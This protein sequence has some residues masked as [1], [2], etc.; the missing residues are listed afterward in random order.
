MED[1]QF[2]HKE[3][4]ALW[5][6]HKDVLAKTSQSY[7]DHILGDLNK[8]IDQFIE[9]K[10]TV[11]DFSSKSEEE[12]LP[13]RNCRKTV[14]EILKQQKNKLS[15]DY[16]TQKSLDPAIKLIK[17]LALKEKYSIV[18]K[19][20]FQGY[21]LKSNGRILL[22]L[23]KLW[24][25]LKLGFNTQLKVFYNLSRKLFRRELLDVQS[26]RKRR[27]LYRNMMIHYLGLE[28]QNKLIP[29]LKELMVFKSEILSKAWDLDDISVDDLEL[30]E[31]LNKEKDILN[32]SEFDEKLLEL[33]NLVSSRNKDFQ[34]KTD[35]A[36]LEA[37]QQFDLDFA[38]ADTPDLSNKKFTKNNLKQ[39]EENLFNNCESFLQKWELTHLALIDDW[40]LDVEIM[41]LYFNVLN[42][43]AQLNHQIS[44]YVNQNLSLNLEKLK[45]YLNESYQRI[46]NTKTTKELRSLL[47]LERKKNSSEFVD[48]ML[49]GTINKI[50]D[51]INQYLNSFNEKTLIFVDQVS[52]KRAF[53]QGK[54]YSKA[55]KTSDVSWLSPQDLLRFEAL[56]GLAN[57]IKD[58]ETFVSSHLEKAR[59]KLIALGTVSDF[60]LESAQ[61]MINE[62]KASYKEA[63][64][65]VFDGYER[66]LKHLE[67]A[68]KE[69]TAI[70]EDPIKDLQA[71]IFSFNKNIQKLKN[72]ENILELQMRIVKIKAIERSKKVRQD[73]WDW[74]IH[75]VPKTKKIISNKF[76]ESNSAVNQIKKSLGIKSEKPHIS[77]ELSDFIRKTEDSLNK[78]P[79]VY[80][81][82]YQLTPTDED[83]FFV[84]R[85][86]ELETLKKAYK[87]WQNNQ[88]VTSAIIGEKG[89]G[90][91]SVILYF[92]K[93]IEKEHPV[94]Q[95]ELNKKIYEPEDYYA[96]FAEAFEV[97]S[98]SNN[99]EIIELINHRKEKSIIIIENLQHLYLK[100]V[101]G[102]VCQ[103]MLFDL[104]T[105]TWSQLF[106]V[107]AYTSHSWEYLNKT[108]QISSIFTKEI[109]L[110]KFTDKTL[111]QMIFKRNYLSGYQVEFMV[112]EQ[113]Q[114]IKSKQVKDEKS[115][116]EQLKKSFFKELNQMSNGNVSLA[117]MYWL[118]STHGIEEGIIKI[119]S[120]RDFD[121]SFD[122]ELPANYLFAL[123][124]ILIHDGL[125]LCDYARVFNQP[126]YVCRNDLNPMLEKGLL[127]KPKE[128]Y[129]INPIIF[130]QVVDLLRSH[131]FIN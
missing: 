41:L 123:Q 45:E 93:S 32:R 63:H 3:I 120:L 112:S 20:V 101:K 80:Q 47:T 1:Y 122:K 118:R 42:E 55:S 34:T 69:M 60:S 75:F 38:K 4:A 26:Y 17:D 8:A 6:E 58:V 116:Q 113:N 100:V 64:K 5:K 70:K 37:F 33:Q 39:E 127:I 31:E 129:N 89:G 24:A 106:W 76:K 50:S 56:P 96:F 44:D 52:D 131:N 9:A 88:F 22:F 92:L 124:A 35:A 46:E 85:K 65:V 62:Q 66:A 36:L 105:S 119:Q 29:F 28:Y 84:G 49:S 128:K 94:I 16:Q 43:Y 11:K 53:I 111:E 114:N 109:H 71:A 87:A 107:A 78:L 115:Q 51:K 91:S 82:L 86:T 104:I 15:T 61:M 74:V 10:N 7:F 54:K 117:Q 2:K 68:E 90:I 97:E 21:D 126:E 59:V 25:N 98:F 40:S 79:F 99:E 12:I 23:K 108:L 102:F 19:E 81:R 103:K 110:D 73:A 83:R 57:A 14:L 130:R 125:I 13:I 30:K 27:L 48:K 72:S 67:E 121:V 95:L 77:H 18:K